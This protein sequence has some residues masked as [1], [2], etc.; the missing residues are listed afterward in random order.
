[1]SMTHKNVLIAASALVLVCALAISGAHA[2]R[3]GG[4]YMPGNGVSRLP[5]NGWVHKCDWGKWSSA[6]GERSLYGRFCGPAKLPQ[7]Q[8][9]QQRTARKSDYCGANCQRK[10]LGGGG[11]CGANCQR[12]AAATFGGRL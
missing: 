11:H 2:Q 1:M 5:Q 7:Y 9:V 4:N 8:K 10:A 3:E 12:K 6:P